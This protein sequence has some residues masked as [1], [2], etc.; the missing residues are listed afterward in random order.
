MKSLQEPLKVKALIYLGLPDIANKH[1]GHSIIN[2]LLFIRNTHITDSLYFSWQRYLYCHFENGKKKSSSIG[3]SITTQPCK[4]VELCSRA[5]F[6][7]G[8]WP[9]VVR[10]KAK[11]SLKQSSVMKPGMPTV[12][13]V[14]LWQVPELSGCPF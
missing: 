9:I 5:H 1:T 14:V 4:K 13:Y 7:L 3:H 11:R 6:I 10:R 12:K 2:D 8:I